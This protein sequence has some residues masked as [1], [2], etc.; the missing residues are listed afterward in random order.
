MTQHQ[1]HLIYYFLPFFLESQHSN[2]EENVFVSEVPQWTR[3]V[4]K[5]R[6]LGRPSAGATYDALSTASYVAN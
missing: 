2:D 4:R 5:S 6:R 1:K 3:W